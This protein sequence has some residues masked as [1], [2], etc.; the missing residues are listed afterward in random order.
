MELDSRPSET[1]K[2][3]GR[4]GRVKCWL[5]SARYTVATLAFLFLFAIYLHIVI[6]N[7]FQLENDPCACG[8]FVR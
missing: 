2:R 4:P 7:N 5:V 6:V 8:L 3:R 1:H